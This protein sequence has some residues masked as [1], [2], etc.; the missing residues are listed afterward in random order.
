MWVHHQNRR[1]SNTLIVCCMVAT[2]KGMAQ[3][4]QAIKTYSIC[5]IHYFILSLKSRECV[6]QTA[7][8]F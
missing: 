8:I 3:Q 7:N 6:R 5:I 2:K 1:D 4:Q